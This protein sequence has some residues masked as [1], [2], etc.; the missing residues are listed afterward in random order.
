MYVCM[1]VVLYVC[2]SRLRC[3]VV[4]QEA[5]LFVTQMMCE[6]KAKVRSALSQQWGGWI[7]AFVRAELTDP[8]ATH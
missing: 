2:T 3:V 8:F 7:V 1:Y 6:D 4:S 5:K